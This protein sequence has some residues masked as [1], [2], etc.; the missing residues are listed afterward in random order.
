MCE[1]DA[2]FVIIAE[3]F[4]GSLAL[5][6]FLSKVTVQ[7]MPFVDLLHRMPC[8]VLNIESVAVPSFLSL[9]LPLP[10]PMYSHQM[11]LTSLLTHKKASLSQ[12]DDA[13][14]TFL[15]CLLSQEH[16]LQKHIN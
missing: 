9:S 10:I 1:A 7:P 3:Y 11:I 15:F 14:K 2:G 13:D 8:Q 5:L 16:G 4:Q 6:R 12:Q